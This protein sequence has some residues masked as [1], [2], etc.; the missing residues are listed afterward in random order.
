MKWFF[1]VCAIALIVFC[2]CACTVAK[3]SDEQASE[4]FQR[5]KERKEE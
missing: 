2:F 4:M 1:I 5:F 3:Q